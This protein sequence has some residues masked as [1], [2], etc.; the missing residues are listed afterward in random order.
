MTYR[1]LFL[2]D[3]HKRDLDF[4]TISGYTQAVDLVQADIL[5]FVRDRGITH[6]ISLGDWYD[7]GYRSVNRVNNDRN[8]DEA[9]SEAVNGNF[10]IC[11]GNHFFLERDNNP[12]MYLI[13]PSDL[14][15]P[16]HPIYA[17]KPIIQAP[18]SIRIGSIQ[19]SL[20]H[21]SKAHKLYKTVLDPDVT[22]HVG[23]YH[24]EIVIPTSAQKAGGLIGGTPGTRIEEMLDNVNLAIVG[25]VH[26]PV[27]AI[28]VPVAG[29]E[30]P[31]I[32]PGSLSNTSNGPQFHDSVKLPVLE[33]AEGATK[34][35]CLLYTF[36]LHCEC[37]RLHKPKES[38]VKAEIP[39]QSI[40]DIPKTV[41]VKDYLLAKGFED[42]H[43]QL[44]ET[45]A[46]HP[47]DPLTGLQLLGIVRRKEQ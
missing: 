23:V 27:G 25:H 33:I 32:I 17:E 10:Y 4:S 47:V 29:R 9:L 11:L 39:A 28:K 46:E 12:E 6:L 2:G 43:V 35:A 16:T 31:M 21:F 5:Q 40:A 18:R 42:R 3:L 38:A 8:W 15:K 37:L 19:I 20:F 22:Y 44:V 45:A 34:P 13:Q 41:S 7:K 36:P 30:I 1:V 24:D 26:K 14:Y